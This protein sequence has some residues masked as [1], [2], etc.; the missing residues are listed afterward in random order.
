MTQKER[1]KGWTELEKK[2]VVWVEEHRRATELVGYP[3]PNVK[4][5][6]VTAQERDDDIMLLRQSLGELIPSNE[7]ISSNDSE[8]VMET[9]RSVTP[10]SIHNPYQEEGCQ[11]Y[12]PS[13]YNAYHENYGYHYDYS[14]Q[15]THLGHSHSPYYYYH[16]HH[17][18]HDNA[19][20]NN[21]YYQ[22]SQP[23]YNYQYPNNFY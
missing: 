19:S 2:L 17:Y 20:Y 3:T 11:Y 18:T 8:Q 7:E 5:D 16:H 12:H 23:N 21:T 6:E 15:P 9:P 14:T 22:D 1:S 4:C 10:E 13:V